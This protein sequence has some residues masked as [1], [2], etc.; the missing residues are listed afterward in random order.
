MITLLKTVT[1]EMPRLRVV[2]T[3][4]LVL[5][6]HSDVQRA[7]PL[8][9][10]LRADGV[11]KNPP[12]VA[13]LYEAEEDAQ[14]RFS[15]HG[16]ST[17]GDQPIYVVLDG[18]NR[19]SALQQLKLPAVLV[20]VFRYDSGEV[21]LSNWNHVVSKLD[22]SQLLAGIQA[23]DGLRITETSLLDARADLARRE[24]LA[25]LACPDGKVFA[26]HSRA[27]TLRPRTTLL[28]KM[29]DT[30]KDVSQLYRA[31][32]D[33]PDEVLDYYEEVAALMVFPHYEP[34]EVQALARDG[35]H[36]PAGI[37]RHVVKG[38]AMRLNYP[39]EELSKSTTI[40]E[41]NARFAEWLREKMANKEI[42]Y[43]EEPTFLFDE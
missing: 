13:P 28:N 9:E 7:K 17:K 21:R 30:Y 36:L 22:R 39:L 2:R 12:L 10:R 26:V 24:I 5:H 3:N 19:T 29:V 34:A 16:P 31:N 23:V 38:R 1:P 15:E 14:A 11:L 25:Y 18:A 33:E 40:E 32:T 27:H 41:K 6:E 20:Q 35:I 42:R 4:S 37:T 43:Y 8:A